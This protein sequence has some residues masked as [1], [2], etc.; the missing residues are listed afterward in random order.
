VFFEERQF[1]R[2]RQS[3]LRLSPLLVLFAHFQ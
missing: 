1:P 2:C 3:A